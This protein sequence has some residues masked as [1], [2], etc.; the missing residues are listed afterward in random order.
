MHDPGS[1][2]Q[3]P[4]HILRAAGKYVPSIAHYIL[5]VQARHHALHAAHAPDSMAAAPGSA[6]A[7]PSLALRHRR[8]GTTQ[9]TGDAEGDGGGN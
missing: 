1:L 2:G 3:H 9:R 8:L 5:E 4:L 7:R 6:G